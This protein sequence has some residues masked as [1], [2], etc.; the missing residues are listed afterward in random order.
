MSKFTIILCFVLIFLLIIPITYSTGNSAENT[1]QCVDLPND[2]SDVKGK[3][4]EKGIPNKDHMCGPIAAG[5]SQQWF[6]DKCGVYYL[7]ISK[8]E[9]IRKLAEFMNTA[10][11]N[12]TYIGDVYLGLNEFIRSQ[13]LDQCFS[14]YVKTCN[15]N[16]YISKDRKLSKSDFT[17]PD[18][19][20]INCPRIKD[21]ADELSKRA[22][23]LLF[24]YSQG[25]NKSGHFVAVNSIDFS[26]SEQAEVEL[27]SN[28][29]KTTM[30]L[31]EF[32]NLDQPTQITQKDGKVTYVLM[33]MI[34][35]RPNLDNPSCR[36]KCPGEVGVHNLPQDDVNDPS[37]TG[38]SRESNSINTECGSN[39]LRST[40]SGKSY[41]LNYCPS[42]LTQGSQGNNLA[43]QFCSDS[44]RIEL[45]NKFKLANCL[46]ECPIKSAP[47]YEKA[48]RC[49]TLDPGS[50]LYCGWKVSFN[51]TPQSS[52]KTLAPEFPFGTI[53]LAISLSIIGVFLIKRR[54]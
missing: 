26:N 34:S 33:T 44:N 4:L 11:N 47:T 3:G 21:I 6:N 24:F 15:N 29:I 39:I 32:K 43:L 41:E 12:G 36:F 28:D 45:E 51:C 38:T 50:A 52:T 9:K 46:P 8:E 14:I 23:V 13:G 5:V 10:E 48:P 18:E 53:I 19:L 40:L 30:Y 27:I 54:N 7:D 1:A 49:T 31:D 2:P 42:Y 16:L 37:F 22:D 17:N 20:G 25:T 35:V